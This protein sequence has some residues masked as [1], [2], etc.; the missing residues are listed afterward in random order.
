MSAGHG[1]N[2]RVGIAEIQNCC[3]VQE[4]VEPWQGTF[5]SARHRPKR[6]ISSPGD[7]HNPGVWVDYDLLRKHHGGSHEIVLHS[8]DA[9]ANNCYFALAA[10]ALGNNKAKKKA[11]ATPEL[12][13]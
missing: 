3:S 11:K 9:A 2:F 8:P 6:S 7:D 5:K 12:E 13:R 10:L 4:T 1:S